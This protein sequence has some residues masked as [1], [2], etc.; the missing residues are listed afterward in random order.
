LF[1]SFFP[2]AVG[3]DPYGNELYAGIWISRSFLEVVVEIWTFRDT[4][5]H[6]SKEFMSIG[7]IN[8]KNI[9]YTIFFF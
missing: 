7:F 8:L 5:A 6:P 9:F 2:N 1:F 4:F 3:K